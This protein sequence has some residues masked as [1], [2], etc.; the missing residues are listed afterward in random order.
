MASIYTEVELDALREVA[1]IGSSTAATALSRLIGMPVEVSTPVAHA[2]GL[3]D[4]IEEA[5]PGE[6]IVTMV[7]LPVSGDV[8]AL[9]LLVLRP[10][11]EA[12]ACR[13]VGVEADTD[14]GRSALAE[15]G[16][17]LGSSYLGA[18]ATLTGLKL[19][20]SPPEVVKDMLGAVLASL[21]VANGDDE[22]V[23]LLESSLS[24]A[25]QECTPS[26][27]FVPTKGCVGDILARI[28]LPT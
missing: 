13:L 1:N 11:S 10:K 25:D 6:L 20:T 14:V 17:I 22:Q 2:L 28:G 12:T 24:V 27:L 4:A 8:E 15:I 19:E 5:G 16:N 3:A 18:L 21:L 9:V 23:L 26:F 7:I